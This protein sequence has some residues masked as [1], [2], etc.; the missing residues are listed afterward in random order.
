MRVASFNANNLF[1]EFN[2][3]VELEREPTRDEVATAAL[4]IRRRGPDA[5]KPLKEL[6]LPELTPAGGL[7][8]QKPI[9]ERRRLAERIIALDADVLLL[10]EVEHRDALREFNRTPVAEGGL[11]GLYRWVASIDGNDPRRIDVGVL[12]RVPLGAVTSWQHVEH[13]EA[14]GD[15]IFSRDL[16]EIDI[17]T[18]NFAAV[19]L[20]C[21]VSHLKSHFVPWERDQTA[22]DVRA[23][24]RA[25]D[26]RRTRQ[27]DMIARI[28]ARRQ[29]KHPHVVAGDFN[30][31]PDAP[32]MAPLAAAA[33]G[34]T[35][36]LADAV[37]DK[38]YA[39]HEEDPPPATGIWSYR[40]RED[41]QTT[42]RLFDHIWLS[43]AAAAA[44][45]GAGIGRR[46]QKGKDGSDHDPVWV[47]LELP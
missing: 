4:A 45:T 5:N 36:G 33:T 2:F 31:P 28:L 3:A 11:G 46:L 35:D 29:L 27:A 34:L 40:H 39:L 22:A 19:R 6:G 23:A 30:D 18:E 15:P 38:P 1:D 42:Y 47:D 14:P 16:L 9:K 37:E 10:Q 24:H 12:T 21:F 20:T 26:L 25:A 7:V 17:L 32:T 44:K 41:G 43:P 8:R 13:P